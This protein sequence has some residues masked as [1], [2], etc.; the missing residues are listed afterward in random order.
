MKKSIKIPTRFIRQT[1]NGQTVIT[2]SKDQK[3][4]VIFIPLT[5][6][7][8]WSQ[9]DYREINFDP[10][11][12]YKVQVNEPSLSAEPM[13]GLVDGAI[14]EKDLQQLIDYGNQKNVN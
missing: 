8:D 5:D 3:L 1:Q 4:F 13:V 9:I 10:E 14:I 7:V 11:Q 6:I 2:Y 12:E